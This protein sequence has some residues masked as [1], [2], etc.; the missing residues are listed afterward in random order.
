MGCVAATYVPGLKK[1]MMCVT[2]STNRKAKG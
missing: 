1:H 2:R